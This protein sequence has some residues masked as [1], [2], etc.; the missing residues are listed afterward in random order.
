MRKL[1]WIILSIAFLGATF[2]VDL[3]ADTTVEPDLL[4]LIRSVPPRD[5]FPH[6]SYYIITDSTKVVLNEDG[7]FEKEIYFL[8]KIY[9]YMGKRRLANYKIYYNADFQKVELLRARTINGDKAMPIEPASINDITPPEYSDASIY[10]NLLAKVLSLPAVSESSVVEIHAK[11]KTDKDAPIPFGAMEV[12]VRTEPSRKTFYE[13]DYP[14]GKKISFLSATSAPKPTKKPGMLRWIIKNY[15]GVNYEPGTPPL[16]EVFP[17][18][19]Y[20]A[21]R[22]WAD[23]AKFI[24]THISPKIVLNDTIKAIADSLIKG[25]KG[26]EVLSALLRFVQDRF[27]QINTKFEYHGF[28]PHSA[29]EVLRNGRGDSKD[30]SVLLIAL[31][32]AAKI[33]A[34]PMLISSYGAKIFNIPTAYQFNKVVVSAVLNGKTYYLDPSSQYAPLNFLGPAA[35]GYALLVDLGTKKLTKLPADIPESNMAVY[36]F[37]IGVD[38]D[39]RAEGSIGVTA[40][41]IPGEKLRKL[42]RYKKKS[43]IKQTLQE[44]ASK[45]IPGAKFDGDTIFENI[46]TNEGMAS[47][48]FTIY[49]EQYM[50]RQGNMAIIWFPELPFELVDIPNI[51]LEERKL[52]LFVDYSRKIMLQN[53]IKFPADYEVVY[54]PPMQNIKTPFGTYVVSGQYGDYSA[55]YNIAFT[56]N[57]KVIKPEEYIKFKEL[58]KNL[59]KKANRIILLK[60]EE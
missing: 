15:K 52:P 57:K 55:V 37:D 23:E 41:G 21:S 18:I 56:L 27:T 28:V 6:A 50:I 30:L 53:V 12:L 44:A 42:F 19:F 48:Q 29:A 25:K 4:R 9:T 24:Y 5:S 33:P 14:K 49:A 34:K 8:A 10:G 60:L 47:V 2:A 40:S 7:S 54:A 36:S 59:H 35:G 45:V 43:Q 39:G 38:L 26:E 11:I 3:S 16:R 1:A 20:S 51:S 46:N 13:V 31:L 58:V 22:S 17:T 32:K